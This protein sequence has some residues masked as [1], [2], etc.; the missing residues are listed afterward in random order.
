[1]L[2]R[3]IC[4]I[5]LTSFVLSMTACE[6]DNKG[7]VFTKGIT[8]KQISIENYF[9]DSSGQNETF[10]LLEVDFNTNEISALGTI[11]YNS[12]T[13]LQSI[14][15]Q[16]SAAL[17]NGKKVVAGINGDMY[18][19]DSA[20]GPGIGT[21]SCPTIV[22]GILYNSFLYKESAS[23]LPIFTIDSNN[24]P[25]ITH[26][27]LDINIDFY[28]KNGNTQ[29]YNTWLFNRNFTVINSIVVFNSRI[30]NDGILEILTD[31]ESLYK[32]NLT[33]ATFITIAGIPDA[34][35]V[36]VGKTYSGVVQSCT[37][38]DGNNVF[39]VPDDCFLIV[40]LISQI[41]YPSNIKNAD[42]TFNINEMDK[43]GDF[44]IPRRDIMQSIG[45]Y[46]WLIKDG[47][48]QTE[49]IYKE[50]KYPIINNIITE[51]LPRTGLGLKQDGTLI[52]AVV[53]GYSENS[54]GLTM[55][56]WACYFDSLGCINAI[57][58][59]GGRSTEMVVLDKEKKGFVSINEV[60][61]GISRPISTGLLFTTQSNNIRGYGDASYIQTII[62]STLAVLILIPCI[63][64]SYVYIKKKQAKKSWR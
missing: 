22:D 57:N 30:K 50:K 5:V 9:N 56:E 11:S 55:E 23:K 42:I 7:Y 21:P 13:G 27:Q 48:V 45:S 15:E 53:D 38:Y 28:Y 60:P 26:L 3:I 44:S 33:Q 59:D 52:A 14:G 32:V 12:A 40:D 17:N 34:S 35:E 24:N 41:Y 4:F 49:K 1:M 20:F 54:A 62:I 47:E 46:N 2:K 8:H 58:F 61:D 39:N 51:R 31:M 29:T 10:N 18:A 19:M 37:K 6:F 36:K 64:Y 43:N 25:D 16:A 63:Y